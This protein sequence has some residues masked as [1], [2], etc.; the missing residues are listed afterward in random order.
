MRL[1][2]GGAAC[3]ALGNR[4]NLHQCNTNNNADKNDG[5]PRERTTSRSGTFSSSQLPQT[6]SGACATRRTSRKPTSAQ[7]KT[8][9]ANM[10]CEVNILTAVDVLSIGL[11]YV[12]FNPTRQKRVN[13]DRNMKRFKQF[14]GPDPST[15]VPFFQDLR[16]AFPSLRYKDALMTLNWLYLNDKQSVLSGRWGCC[17]EYDAVSE[18]EEN[19]V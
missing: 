19:Q 10:Y 17:E 5:Q 15:I 4:L 6:Q 18:G 8:L 14:F 9:T 13:L 2:G 7:P 16:N 1:G 11:S 12:G 3:Q